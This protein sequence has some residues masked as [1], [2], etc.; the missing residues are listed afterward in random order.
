MFDQLPPNI[1]KF[2]KKQKVGH[3]SVRTRRG[4]LVHPIAY[5]IQKTAMVFGTP[6]TARKLDMLKKNPRVSF[7]VDNGKLMKDAVGITVLARKNRNLRS[8]RHRKGR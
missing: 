1:S 7:T 4:V 2:V 3:L 6:R 5:H 8:R